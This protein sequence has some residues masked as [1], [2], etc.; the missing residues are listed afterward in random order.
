MATREEFVRASGGGAAAVEV[1][2]RVLSIGRSLLPECAIEVLDKR[3][4]EPT[5]EYWDFLLSQ[6]EGMSAD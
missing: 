2:D 1:E 5:P 6:L 3:V 4:R